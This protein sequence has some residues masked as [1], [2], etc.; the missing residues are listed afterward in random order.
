[1]PELQHSRAIDS[2]ANDR[3]QDHPPRVRGLRM[4]QPWDGLRENIQRADD[5]HDRVNQR[6]QQRP[7]AIAVGIT[8]VATP[9]GMPLQVPRQAQRKAIAQ[10][11]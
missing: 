9:L 6:A 10:I 2:D 7:A 5:E 8:G 1:M 3:Q 11:V 4:Q